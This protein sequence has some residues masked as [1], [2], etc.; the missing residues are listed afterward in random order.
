MDRAQELGY[1]AL[2]MTEHGTTTGLVAFYKECHKQGIKPILGYEG[3]L[4]NE[5]NVRSN[6]TYHILLLAKNVTGYRNILKIATYATENFYYKPRLSLDYLIENGDGIIVTTACMGG[7]L[8]MPDYDNTIERLIKGFGDDFYFEI[9]TNSLPEQRV[10]NKLVLSLCDKYNTNN[11]VATI[12]SHYV[13]REDAPIHRKWKMLSDDSE[14]YS[15][16][17]YY[18][19]DEAD[20]RSRLSYIDNKYVDIAIA[21]SIAIADKCDVVIPFGD[22]NYPTAGV[23]DG[24]AY[25]KDRMNKGWNDKGIARL[26]D[27]KEYVKRGNMELDVLKQVG[28]IDYLCI[29]HD[30]V[31][32]A[33]GNL[34]GHYAPVGFGRGSV[35]GSL[36]SY[37]M[38][39]TAVDPIGYN[40]VFERFTNTERISPPDVD[41]DFPKSRRHEV[42]DY[43]KAKYGD[44]YQIRTT[45]YI[46][47]KAALQRA[48][49]ALKVAPA[50]VDVVSK[51]MTTL[52]ELPDSEMR[53]LA[54]RFVGHIQNFG[55][56][57]SA[58]VVFPDSPDKWVAIEKSGDNMVA[59]ISDFAYLEEQGLLKLDI[60]GLETLDVISNA[61]GSIRKHSDISID[62]VALD[63]QKTS[64][65][66]AMGNT[67]GCFQVESSIMT[68]I[69]RGIGISSVQDLVHCVA[70]GRPGTLDSGMTDA[71][72]RRRNGEPIS[73][74]HPKLRDILLDTEGVI[75]YQ[76]QI[77]QIAREL[78]GYS[79]GEADVLRY[80]I[81]KKKVDM[82]EK[83]MAEFVER[84]VKCGIDR[85][86]MDE[87]SEQIV[88]FGNYGFN[89]GHSAAYGYTAWITAWLKA[90]YPAE[91]M[92]ALINSSH[93]DKGKILG[94]I[95]NAKQ[96]GIS[97]LSPSI[98]DSKMETAVDGNGGIRL[99]IGCISG[100]GNNVIKTGEDMADFCAFMAVRGNVNKTALKNIIKAGC[101]E[102]DRNMLLASLEWYKDK[103]KNKGEFSDYCNKIL[104]NHDYVSMERD[105]LGFSLSNRF[106]G[107]DISS[108][109][110]SSLIA[111]EV[112]ETKAHTTKKGKP[113]AFVKAQ[114]NLRIYDLVCFDERCSDIAVG[115]VYLFKLNDTIIRDFCKAK[116]LA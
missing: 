80:V 79:Y 26:P 17:D 40:L 92:A 82:I 16:D 93:G 28:Y 81:G 89:R 85:E 30:I 56:H 50:H 47:E 95:Y 21:N 48:G 10:H 88:T 41:V 57:A 84:G 42:I 34:E 66:L 52:A 8:S 58:V 107:Y 94:Y 75:L 78:C 2:A 7:V 99:G 71:F 98:V 101:F 14:Y 38:G 72:I 43:I 106:T 3:Y 74:L 1:P 31:E 25:I 112:V 96:M 11:V 59:A 91:F 102:G 12:D 77:M 20:V 33:R 114:D 32:W 36:V 109:N 83:C 108:A 5:I 13:L 70:L 55:V 65:M 22:I 35:A 27:A 68:K 90:N 76:E 86:V 4:A 37:L 63:C 53:D 97:V 104:T 64:D 54:M 9:Q 6:S 15:T 46:G 115:E 49:Q 73:Y 45:N 113:M 67:A 51:S 100:V 18:L 23:G 69:I 110:G 103:R 39:I 19:M 87:L 111:V 61:I 24:V 62:D 44:V 105:A 60:L 29:V 116:K